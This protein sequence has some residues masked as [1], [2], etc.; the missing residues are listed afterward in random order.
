MKFTS[1]E[2]P[3]VFELSEQFS[4]I[5]RD[6]LTEDELEQVNTA[7]LN[8]GDSCETHEFCDPNEAMLQA[9]NKAFNCELDLQDP[10]HVELFNRAW[11][12]SKKRNFKN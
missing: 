7:N 11:A 5:I 2:P 10:L 4:G 9:F 6:W 12:V 1:I 8:S 3:H